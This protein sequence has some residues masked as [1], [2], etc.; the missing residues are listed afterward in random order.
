MTFY[1]LEANE[2]HGMKTNEWIVVSIQWKTLEI[3]W[4]CDTQAHV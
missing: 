3:E 2:C 4:H 1:H